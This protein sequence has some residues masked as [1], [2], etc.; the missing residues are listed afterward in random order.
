LAGL[1]Q[2]RAAPDLDNRVTLYGKIVLVVRGFELHNGLLDP[3]YQK[4]L[5]ILV[6]KQTSIDVKA[7]YTVYYVTD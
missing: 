6:S 2:E 3:I 7:E 4:G 5:E 1:I